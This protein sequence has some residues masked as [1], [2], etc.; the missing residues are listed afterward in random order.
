MLEK[1]KQ[2]SLELEHIDT[3][4]YTPEEYEGCIV[5]LQ[6]VNHWLGDASALRTTLLRDVEAEHLQEFSVLDIGA[7]SGELL[8]VTARWARQSGRNL[9]AVGLELNER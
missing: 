4:N 8:R 6:R 3:G 2:R 9:S 5:E 7:G 1:F